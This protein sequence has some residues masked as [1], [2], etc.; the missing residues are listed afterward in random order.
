MQFQKVRKKAVTVEAF[1]F[2]QQEAE[3]LTRAEGLDKW[4]GNTH[5][6]GCIVKICGVKF[7]AGLDRDNKI[8]FKIGTLEGEHKVTPG[9]W[10]IKGVKGEHYPCKPDVFKKTY[11]LV[12]EKK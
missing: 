12:G 3:K 6:T 9:D 4:K 2:D 11:D 1:Q 7:F 5:T 8:Q 10:I